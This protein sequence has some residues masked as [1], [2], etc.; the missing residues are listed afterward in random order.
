MST[1]GVSDILEK[2]VK[3]SLVSCLL[4]NAAIPQLVTGFYPPL[5]TTTLTLLCCSIDT[6]E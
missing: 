3:Y 5:S 4:F 6:A 1:A 2:T